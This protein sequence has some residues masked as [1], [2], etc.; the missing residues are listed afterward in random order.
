MRT[1]IGWA[2]AQ[3]I[4]CTEYEIRAEGGERM[5]FALSSYEQGNTRAAS[6]CYMCLLHAQI[7]LQSSSCIRLPEALGG[8]HLLSVI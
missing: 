8:W 6:M 7:R 4:A 2:N 1:N 5:L 3:R